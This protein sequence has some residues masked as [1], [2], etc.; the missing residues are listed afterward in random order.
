[1][2]QVFQNL[3][4]NAVKF[5]DKPKGYIR[6]GCVEENGFWKFSV[7]DNGCGIKEKYFEKIFEIFHTLTRRDEIE[8]TGI[9]LTTVKKIIEKYDG[10]IWVESE[11]QKGSTFF[12]TLPKQ[13]ME[14]KNEKFQ[15][16]TAG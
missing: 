9:G 2:V 3:L 1:M 13:E 16:N 10:K 4:G 11:P 8:G 12:F 7:A 15:T 5:M 14:T 6:L